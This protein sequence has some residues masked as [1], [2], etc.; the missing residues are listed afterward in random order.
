MPETE[1]VVS[2]CAGLVTVDKSSDIVRLVHPTAQEYFSQRLDTWFPDAR[3]HMA[4]ACVSYLSFSAFASGFCKTDAEFEARLQSHPFYRHAAQNWGYH[5]C[6]A[7][8]LGDEVGLFLQNE[9]RTEAAGQALLASNRYFPRPDYSQ[10]VPSRMTGLHLA[11]CFGAG[12]LVQDLLSRL[13]SSADLRDS[14]DRTPLSWA[15]IAFGREDV[16]EL[17]LRSGKVDPECKDYNTGGRTPL[18]S[19]A[20]N[21]LVSVVELLLRD[22][23]V[24]PNSKDKAG[25]TPLYW[26]VSNGHKEVD[27]ATRN[28]PSWTSS[29][30][31][32]RGGTPR[33]ADGAP[34]ALCWAAENGRCSIFTLLLTSDGGADVNCR[35]DKG[36]TPP[37]EG[38]WRITTA[39]RRCP[40]PPSTARTPSSTSCSL[41][42]KKV[43]VDSRDNFG[44]TPLS[45]ASEYGHQAIARRLLNSGRVEVDA[46]DKYYEQTPLFW[47][48]RKG[49]DAVV[50]LLLATGKVDVNSRSVPRPTGTITL[51]PSSC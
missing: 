17:L 12:N 21:G 34:K 16:A 5:A 13:S 27:T 41:P 35:D 20:E 8:T 45:K 44:R 38:L 42:E 33:N 14:H 40:W 25:R 9:A 24:N 47:A 18:S 4:T 10:D 39:E 29:R 7:N 46:K 49:H 51:L 30:P 26:A 28:R 50:E 23:R 2:A 31:P 32:P 22:R 48:A 1:S 15:N 19:A 36:T 6:E 37:H 3:A 11:A 43:E